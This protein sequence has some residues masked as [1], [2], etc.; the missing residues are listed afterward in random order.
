[1]WAKVIVDNIPDESLTGEWGLCI[2]IKAA[3][4]VI[5]L[6]AGASDLFVSNAKQLGIDLDDVDMAVLSHAHSDHANGM[7]AFFTHNDHAKFYVQASSAP[8]CYYKKWFT[9]RYIGIPR[10]ILDEFSDRIELVDGKLQLADGLWLLP[11][12]TQNLQRV[13]VREHMYL[14]TANGWRPDDFSHEQSLVIETGKGLVIF[15][16]CSHGGAANIINEVT[17]AFPGKSVYGI[18]GGFHLYN[19]KP[20]EVRE[21]AQKIRA[22]GIRYICTGHC[23][24]DRAYAILQ[25][26]LGEQ[27]HQLHVGLVMEF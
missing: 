9:R 19:K 25:Q 17:A 26:E 24:G 2:L 10:N 11:H 21:L 18:I 23:T 27:L 16:S 15:N 14:R 12:T 4:K 20:A 5:L 6:D 13:G 22:T 8:N 7:E 3:G 1:M